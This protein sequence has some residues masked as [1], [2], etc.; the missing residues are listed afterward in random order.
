M[1]GMGENS[2]VIIVSAGRGGVSRNC[3]EISSSF[4]TDGGTGTGAV[5]A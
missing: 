3:N 2:G 5:R 4:A 1:K